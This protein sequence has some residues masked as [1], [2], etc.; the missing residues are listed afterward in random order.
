MVLFGKRIL[1]LN[2]Y[3]NPMELIPRR[4]LGLISALFGTTRE[5]VGRRKDPHG[6]NEALTSKDVQE[7]A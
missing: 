6:Q 1:K 3:S 4:L 5:L 2:S 7:D